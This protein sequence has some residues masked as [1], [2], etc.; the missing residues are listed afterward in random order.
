MEQRAMETGHV[1]LEALHRLTI[2]PQAAVDTTQVMLRHY[3]EANIP[4]GSSNGQGAL[5]GREGTVRVTH[6]RKMGEEIDCDP[7]QPVLV[8]QGLSEPGGFL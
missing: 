2:V 7:S 8:S 1:L 4:Q 3:C 6:L 5:T